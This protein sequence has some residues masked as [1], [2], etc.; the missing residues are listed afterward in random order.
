MKTPALRALHTI[1]VLV[2]SLLLLGCASTPA[3]QEATDQPIVAT[4]LVQS[5]TSWDGKL[6]PAYP[7]TQPEITILRIRIA[8][9]ARLPL[10]HHPVINAGVLL[11]GQLKIETVSG[12]VLHL[13]AGDPIVETVNMVHYGVNDGTVPADIIVVYAGTVD[14]PF[15]VIEKP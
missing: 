10:H 15:T 14:H 6:L 8:P 1:P 3:H 2:L 12:A 9:G 4:K 7:T 11:T 13:K 5:K